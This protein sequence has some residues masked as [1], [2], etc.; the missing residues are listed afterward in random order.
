MT[1]ENLQEI[2]PA[3]PQAELQNAISGLSGEFFSKLS[4]ELRSE[5]L[6]I[7]M[8]SLQRVYVLFI[9]IPSICLFSEPKL[10]L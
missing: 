4:K 6:V 7:I 1:M 5:C 8:D 9:N 3:V 2:L 10:M